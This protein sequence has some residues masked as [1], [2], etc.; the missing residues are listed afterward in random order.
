MITYV[1]YYKPMLEREYIFH[2]SPMTFD[3][4]TLNE[5]VMIV[6]GSI[7]QMQSDMADEDFFESMA[8][9]FWDR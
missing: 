9:D 1:H 5:C 8:A 7:Q 6:P 4:A 2:P 3:Y